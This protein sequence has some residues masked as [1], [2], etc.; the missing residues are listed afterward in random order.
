MST[1][2]KINLLK[3]EG[4]GKKSSQSYIT[5]A[6]KLTQWL[7]AF[8]ALPRGLGAHTMAHTIETAMP[9]NLMPSSVLHGH[10]THEV[11]LHI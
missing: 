10:G 9:K 7:G 1:Q 8:A 11:H 5:E 6:R 2:F 3:K 4:E